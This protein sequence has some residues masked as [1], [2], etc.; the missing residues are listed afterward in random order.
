MTIN[1]IACRVQALNNSAP[2]LTKKRPAPKP[3]ALPNTDE[4]LAMTAARIVAALHLEDRGV[5]VPLLVA[6][7][8]TFEE[9]QYKGPIQ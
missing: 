9:E 1:E 3:A 4:V 6:Q 7:V 5:T 2:P 8:K